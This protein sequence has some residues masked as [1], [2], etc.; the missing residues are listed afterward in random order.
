MLDSVL[1][2]FSAFGWWRPWHGQLSTILALCLTGWFPSRGDVITNLQCFMSLWKSCWTNNQVMVNFP[3]SK[4]HGANMGSIWGR[5]DPD[6]PHVCPMK[7]AIWVQ[8]PC[9]SCDIARTNADL[10]IFKTRHGVT[11]PQWVNL[12]WEK[13]PFSPRSMSACSLMAITSL[14]ITCFRLDLQADGTSYK[15]HHQALYFMVFQK[16][17]QNML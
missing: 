2:T 7:F 5:Q 9:R 13:A 8:T 10:L 4:V 6:G 15:T 17:V 1:S 16:L 11:R 3:D 14:V 12:L